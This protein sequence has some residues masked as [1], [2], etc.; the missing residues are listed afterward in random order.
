M[1]ECVDQLN[2]GWKISQG[3]THH[4][5]KLF[6]TYKQQSSSFILHIFVQ[7]LVSLLHPSHPTYNPCHTIPCVPDKYLS[8]TGRSYEPGLEAAVLTYLS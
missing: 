8:T 4:S 3:K 5:G 6:R 7:Q 2:G 1:V